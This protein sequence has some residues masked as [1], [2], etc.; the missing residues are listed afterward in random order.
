MHAELVEISETKKR[1]SIE[2]PSEHVTAEVDRVAAG[3]AKKTRIPGFRQGKVPVRVVK[4]RFRDQVL[5]DAANAL[6]PRALDAA[7]QLK[8][9]EP[10]D[11][12][13]VQE[14]VLEEGKPLT[15]TATFETLP[16]FTVG[17]YAAITI[18][19]P[20]TAVSDEAVHEALEKLRE[21]AARAEGVEGRGLIDGDLAVVDLERK[22]AD[23][24]TDAHTDVQIEL[25]ATANP[26]GF[27]AQ[28]LGLEVGASKTFTVTYPADYSVTELAGTE[29]E[30]RVALKAIRRRVL[31]TLDDAFAKEMG[32]FESLD[33]LRARVRGDLE[34]EATH[35]ADRETRAALTTQLAGKVPFDIPAA[36][37]DRELDRR[38]NEFAR[39]LMD[40]GIDPR[41]A[42]L[43]WNAFRESQRTA[44]KEAVGAAIALDE[45]ARQEHIEVTDGDIDAEIARYAQRVGRS[46]EEVRVALDKEQGVPRISAGIR[47]EKCVDFV[48]ARATI[49]GA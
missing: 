16:P 7:L 23:G 9:L 38:L 17:D 41:K 28:L 11:T 24:G 43:D 45:I 20:S 30:Y 37:V 4:Q 42:G 40:Q 18:T 47:R 33:A 1:L 3:L 36:L 2:L 10:V 26:P 34:H 35:T 5:Y 27:D 25:G 31:P 46:V 39:Q 8:G 13:D 19:K 6:V 29:M 21:R 12:P 14:V 49:A 32:G 15:F 48:M 22:D 44:A